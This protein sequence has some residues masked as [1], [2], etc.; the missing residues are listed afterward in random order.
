LN[1]GNIQIHSGTVTGAP[2]CGGAVTT[3]A[4]E[5][6]RPE[7]TIAAL[8]FEARVYPN[9]TST[10]FDLYVASDNINDKVEIKVHDIMGKQI[11]IMNGA[12]NKTYQFGSN[13]ING[14]Y[15]VEVRQG[16]KTSILKLIKQ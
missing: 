2:T 15:F 14:I 12:A 11:Q 10:Q 7:E 8:K 5:A 6:L 1:G 13:Y 9:P 4:S 16:N 3:R